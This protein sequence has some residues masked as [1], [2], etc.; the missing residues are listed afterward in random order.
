[1]LNTQGYIVVHYLILPLKLYRL[2]QTEHCTFKYIQFLLCMTWASC[3]DRRSFRCKSIRFSGY[4]CCYL[5]YVCRWKNGLHHGVYSK[6]VF[7]IQWCTGISWHIIKSIDIWRLLNHSG[8]KVLLLFTTKVIKC[9]LG[10]SLWLNI[11]EKLLLVCFFYSI[12]LSIWDQ[13]FM[14]PCSIMFR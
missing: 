14:G 11:N 1:M 2:I 6:H 8:L 3:W 12:C 5:S 7:G 9:V 13:S 4:L 10:Q